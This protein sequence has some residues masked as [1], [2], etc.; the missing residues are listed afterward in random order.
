MNA[1]ASPSWNSFEVPTPTITS[2]NPPEAP[3]TGIIT[4][5][6][7]GFG[8]S[9]AYSPDGVSVVFTGFVQFNGAQVEA[10]SW[11]DTSLTVRVP[12]TALSGPITILKYDAVSNGQPFTIEGAPTVASLSPAKG[13]V[14]STVIV[15]GSGFGAQFKVEALFP[16]MGFR[17]LSSTPGVT[18]PS[19][20][21]YPLAPAPGLSVSPWPASGGRHPPSLS[22]PRFKSQIL[23]GTSLPTPQQI[24]E[25][26]GSQRMRRAPD[27][28]VA[29]SVATFIRIL[30]PVLVW[31]RRLPMNLVTPQTSVM[32]R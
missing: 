1:T 5:T 23:S 10:L 26:A 27:V 2:V 17:R 15:N 28:Q 22:I 11:S 20:L 24:S 6:G 32:T 29:P 16:S 19:V 25:V 8:A 31:S 21:S 18:L 14:G 13:P 4:I 7:T 30:T 12:E 9:G 3:Q